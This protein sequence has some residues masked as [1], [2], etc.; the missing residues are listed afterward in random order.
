MINNEVRVRFAPSPTGHL[1]VGGARTALFNYLFAKRHGGVFILRLEDT[2]AARSRDEYYRGILDA[3][4][5]LGLGWDE[6]PDRGGPCG[7]YRQSER[8]AIYDEYL[9]KLVA[10]DAAYECFCT[11]EELEARRAEMR[12]AGRAPRYDGRCAALS[13]GE[14]D[15]R[16][17]RGL[18]PC[19]RFRMATGADL[20]FD[21]L[22]R[23]PV[24]IAAEDLDD[25]V[26]ARPDG[27][28]TYNFVCVVDDATMRIS[29]VIRGEDHI[30]NTPRQ[31]AVY[32]ALGLEPPA[33]AHLPLLLGPDKSRLSKRH[34]AKAVVEYRDE[35]YL[36]EAVVNFLALLGWSY[37]DRR[38]IF[39]LEELT[40]VFALERVAKKGAV[41]D[42]EKLNWMNGV[43]IRGLNRDGLY[44]R[45]R[46]WL[47]GAGFAGADEE[48][49][50]AA[51]A[52][53]QE[54]MKTLVEA[55]RLTE[56]FFRDDFEYDTKAAANLRNVPG[57]GATFEELMDSFRGASEFDADSLEAVVRGVAVTRGAPAGKI[58]HAL[59]AAL[60]G[61]VAGPSLFAMATMAPGY[62]KA[63]L[64]ATVK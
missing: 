53:E 6:G 3:L 29:H 50:A 14:R 32:R 27:S 54:K 49:A 1:H 9:R 55:P 25:F 35:G 59:R 43:Y 20:S 37:D 8:G 11:P 61:R 17:T 21:D 18:R 15:E 7:P 62:W 5:W 28:G 51:L 22:I 31:I 39:T 58:I 4:T 10:A 40:R 41:F 42:V 30:S 2:D 36:A 24:A 52:L 47:E 45:A 16:R 12:V 26:I 57:G 63:E 64:L 48:Y 19:Y 23:G 44:A 33:F 34:G 60:S 38:E 46:C 56:F 13:P